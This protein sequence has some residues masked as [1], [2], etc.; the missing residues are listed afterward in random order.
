MKLILM[1]T[2]LSLQGKDDCTVTPAS[3]HNPHSA[4]TPSGEHWSNQLS[5]KMARI[6]TE[7]CYAVNEQNCEL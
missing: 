4:V 5:E 7:L 6:R 1:L 3:M 2:S